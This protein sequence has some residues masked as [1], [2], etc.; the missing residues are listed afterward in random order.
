MA[1]AIGNVQGWLYITLGRAHRQ[2]VYYL[3]TRP[4]IIGGFFVGIWWNGM[5]GLALVYGTVTVLMLVPGFAFAIR[6]T[7][8]A[9]ADIVRP[10]V[11]PALLAPLAF[12]AAWAAVSLPSAPGDPRADRRRHRRCR[13]D[14]RGARDP[15]AIG[16]M[17]ARSWRSSRR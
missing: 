6:G 16:V 12:A 17:R 7:F 11:R 15:R 1:Q 3:I 2:L 5:K 10:M 9:A 14:A 4:I 8:V 13:A